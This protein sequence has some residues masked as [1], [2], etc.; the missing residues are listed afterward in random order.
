MSM[1][2]AAS[3]GC[4]DAGRPVS[5]LPA[6]VGVVDESLLS[7]T[8]SFYDTVAGSY[9]ELLTDT[10]F[11]SSVELALVADFVQRLGPGEAV[12]VLD[13]GCGTGRMVGHLRS[14]SDTLAISGVDLSPGMLEHAREAHPDVVFSEGALAAL[15]SPDERFDGVLAWYSIIHTAPHALPPVFAEFHRVLKPGGWLLLGYQSGV[16]DRT[17]TGAYGHDV[18]LHAFLHHTPYVEAALLA[19]GLTVDTR[20]DRAPRREERL[21]QGFVLARRPA[22]DE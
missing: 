1:R 19:A 16:G 2:R 15:P 18:E 9:A 12:E 22:S 8:R 14:L 20:L 4:S 10:S 13:A 3:S 17:R 11:E 5:G 21:P 7:R 6:T